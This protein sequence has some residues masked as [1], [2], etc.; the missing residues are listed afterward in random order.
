MTSSDKAP[1]AAG[2]RPIVPAGHA[3]QVPGLPLAEQNRSRGQQ[4]VASLPFT[5]GGP[6]RPQAG[7][8]ITP[9][10]QGELWDETGKLVMA[11]CQSSSPLARAWLAYDG[12]EI[13]GEGDDGLV[14]RWLTPTAVPENSEMLVAWVEA[15]TGST[16]DAGKPFSMP[17]EEAK[18]Q[19]AL[20]RGF[21][22]QDGPP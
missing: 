2:Q 11:P 15:M 13:I 18:R 20:V 7:L 10:G 19:A 5:T 6:A 14:R 3:F 8:V 22:G 17:L 21:N 16:W 4:P 12:K 1:A 9:D